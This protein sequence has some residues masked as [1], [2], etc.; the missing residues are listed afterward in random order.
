MLVRLNAFGNGLF[1]L[2]YFSWPMGYLLNNQSQILC[3]VSN[4]C[5]SMNKTQIEGIYTGMQIYYG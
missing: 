1:T 5:G 4:L 3:S 2:K